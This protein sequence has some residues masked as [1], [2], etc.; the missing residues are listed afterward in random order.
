MRIET[1]NPR[2]TALAKGDLIRPETDWIWVIR[3]RKSQWAPGYLA[4]K[5]P[6]I[7]NSSG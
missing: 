3:E 2:H 5:S 7:Y 6:Q 4:S 1:S